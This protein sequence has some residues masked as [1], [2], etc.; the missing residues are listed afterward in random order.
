MKELSEIIKECYNNK[1]YN[2]AEILNFKICLIQDKINCR[3]QGD[4][5]N[6]IEYYPCS[7]HYQNI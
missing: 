7:K 5:L 2:E 6:P 3:S 1:R 4:N